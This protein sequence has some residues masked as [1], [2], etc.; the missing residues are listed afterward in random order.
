VSTVPSSALPGRAPR[1]TDMSSR[2]LRMV[3][4]LAVATLALSACS[5]R[6][7]WQESFE[8]AI[9]TALLATDMGITAAEA[10]K[11]TSGFAVNLG[12]GLNFQADDLTTEDLHTMLELIVDNN[13]VSNINDLKV[14]AILGPDNTDVDADVNYIDLGSLG[15]EL[16]F[17]KTDSEF[18]TP[19]V[20]F[21]NWDDVVDYLN[22]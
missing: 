19:E 2:F 10:D 3:G 20:F 4:M 12:V 16:G 6:M 21:A 18:G 5:I 11:S 1:K 7:P 13:N 22:E 15:E 8:T 9:P 17:E 14:F